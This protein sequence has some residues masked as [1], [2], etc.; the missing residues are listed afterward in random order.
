VDYDGETLEQISKK[1]EI[2]VKEIVSLNNIPEDKYEEPLM[3]LQVGLFFR[4]IP[5]SNKPE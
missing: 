1:L 5:N 2:P 3:P 4:S